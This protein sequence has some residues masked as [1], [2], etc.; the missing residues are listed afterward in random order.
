MS[1][2]KKQVLYIALELTAESQEKLKNW[3]END[4][5]PKIQTMRRDWQNYT[6]Y[7]HHMTIAFYTEMTQKTYTWCVSHDAEKFKITAKQFGISNKAMAVKVD[8][9]CLS[10]NSLK[11]ITLAT[12]KDTNGKPVDSN[13]IIEWQDIDY[14]ELEGVVTFYKKYEQEETPKVDH[15]NFR[16]IGIYF[17]INV[18]NDLKNYALQYIRK[19]GWKSYYIVG[20]HI[21]VANKEDA[22]AK[23]LKW[24]DLHIGQEVEFTITKIGWSD[25][26]IAFQVDSLFPSAYDIKHLTLALNT[27]HSDVKSGNARDITNWTDFNNVTMKGIVDYI[28]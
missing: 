28:R 14:I 27:D 25:R 18:V 6:T 20:D 4:M 1:L 16:Y 7:C 10:E 13:T 17:N 5:M 23:I 24:A 11:H 2:P 21:T 26:V 19:L 8:T 12:N 15:E 3:F 9:L 22:T